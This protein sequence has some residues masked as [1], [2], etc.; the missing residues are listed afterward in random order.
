MNAQLVQK[1]IVEDAWDRLFNLVDNKEDD[2]REH[3]DAPIGKH[4][5]YKPHQFWWEPTTATT[6]W[7]VVHFAAAHFVPIE[8]WKWIV[9]QA[10]RSDPTAFYKQRT[11]L[12]ETVFD[13]FFKT[14]L[15][16]VSDSLRACVS[17][18]GAA[19]MFTERSCNAN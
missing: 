10:S 12:G 17:S 6:G 19:P 5:N 7:T 18:P 4:N 3:D 1:A 13:I 16:P 11:A 9:W 14:F 15:N 2:D 8:W